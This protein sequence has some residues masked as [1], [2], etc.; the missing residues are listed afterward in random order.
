MRWKMYKVAMKREDLDNFPEY[1]LPAGFNIR[2]FA[3]GEEA[4]AQVEEKLNK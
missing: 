2:L 1:S 3:A 4:W